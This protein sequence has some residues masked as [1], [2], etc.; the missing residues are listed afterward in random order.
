MKNAKE[1]V[2]ELFE[3][4]LDRVLDDRKDAYLREY[5][6]NE[7]DR[8]YGKQLEKMKDYPTRFKNAKAL[9]LGKN[10]QKEADEI[11]DNKINDNKINDN[12]INENK[13]IEEKAKNQIDLQPSEKDPVLKAK[14]NQ[15]LKQ[16]SEVIRNRHKMKTEYK[17]MAEGENKKLLAAEIEKLDKQILTYAYKTIYRQDVI[18]K[19]DA[20]KADEEWFKKMIN[21]FDVPEVNSKF[22]KVINDSPEFKQKFEEGMKHVNSTDNLDYKIVERAAGCIAH[23]IVN[24]KDPE[25][26]KKMNDLAGQLGIPKN[27]VSQQKTR[28]KKEQ[29]KKTE[30]IK[31]K[32]K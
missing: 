3:N 25:M 29:P 7:I 16:I 22:M 19:Y 13:I 11:N 26:P 9:Y 31:P 17:K 6:K 20:G 8:T 15:E 10:N 32:V 1:K 14:L 4:K 21:A 27:M 2:N 30:E 12:K 23:F 5:V 28:V 24:P 18:S